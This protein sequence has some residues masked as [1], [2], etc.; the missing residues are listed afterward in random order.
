MASLSNEGD[1]ETSSPI[2]SSSTSATR[3]SSNNGSASPRSTG[4]QLVSR[5]R[6][7]RERRR[8]RRPLRAAPTGCV[9]AWPPSD[10]RRRRARRAAASRAVTANPH[11]MA[12]YLRVGFL[13]SSRHGLRA[14]NSDCTVVPPRRRLTRSPTPT[15]VPQ[16]PG[17]GATLIVTLALNWLC[18]IGQTALVSEEGLR[19]QG[20]ES[21]SGHRACVGD[22]V[23]RTAGPW[24]PA[25]H[26]LLQ[27]LERVDYPAPVPV[28]ID[29][30]GREVLS[31]IPGVA[32]HPDASRR[33]RLGTQSREL[34]A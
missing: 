22:A 34:V 1:R 28:G 33:V 3:P 4:C 17:W 27:H 16:P 25:V 29:G 14:R 19:P 9:G 11:A 15:G 8:T 5:R 20:D 23:R 2:P 21:Q 12:F 31:F 18:E 10:C 6:S 32:A 7:R 24:T 26:A 30:L 13:G